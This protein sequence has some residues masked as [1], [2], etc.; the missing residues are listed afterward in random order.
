VRSHLGCHSV[1]RGCE[2]AMILDPSLLAATHPICVTAVSLDYWAATTV[3][4][5]TRAAVN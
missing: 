1:H 3:M 4:P 5:V 2:G